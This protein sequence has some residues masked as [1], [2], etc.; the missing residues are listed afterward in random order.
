MRVWPIS[1]YIRPGITPPP[2][3]AWPTLIKQIVLLMA[4]GAC[5]SAYLLLIASLLGAS[6][7]WFS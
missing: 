7:L 3:Y 2:M 6:L 1:E 4:T 5:L